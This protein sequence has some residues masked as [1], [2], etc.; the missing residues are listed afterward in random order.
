V[1]PGVL[2]DIYLLS[3]LHAEDN[4]NAVRLVFICPIKRW[5]YEYI[6]VKTLQEITLNGKG[7]GSRMDNPNTQATLST[8]HRSNKN[9]A[10]I[11][12]NTGQ[13]IKMM[14]NTGPMKKQ[15]CTKVLA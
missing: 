14:I 8:R 3:T 7:E 11:Q 5:N 9:N 10:Y 15:G 2:Q 4:D 6:T 13:N 1:G 12:H